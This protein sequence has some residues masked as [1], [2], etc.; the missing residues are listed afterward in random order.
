MN[1]YA[2]YT[3]YAQVKHGKKLLSSFG[4]ILTAG[5]QITITAPQLK[6]TFTNETLG[7]TAWFKDAAQSGH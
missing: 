1:V 4:T 2:S 6:T 3:Y 5:S 7:E